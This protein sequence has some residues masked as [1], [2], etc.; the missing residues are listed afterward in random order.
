M[1]E[2]FHAAGLAA[3]SGF[4]PEEELRAEALRPQM[5]DQAIRAFETTVRVAVDGDRVTAFAVLRPSADNDA[6]AKVGE[7]HMFYAH[8]RVWGTGVA[9]LLMADALARLRAAGYRA[10]TLWTAEENHRPRAFY[11]STG[12]RLDGARRSK[13]R[14]GVVFTE[15]RHR[16]EL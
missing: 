10:A 15:L 2:I 16:I 11:R 14:H 13:T 1:S 8:P 12:W 3:W 6:E 4:L 9:R 7:L 5:F